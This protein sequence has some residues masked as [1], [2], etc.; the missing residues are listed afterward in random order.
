M[1]RTTQQVLVAFVMMGVGALAFAQDDAPPFLGIQFTPDG[2]SGV[3]VDDVVAGSPADAAGLQVGDVLLS[4][5]DVYIS[6][7]ILAQALSA[8]SVGDTVTLGVVRD[9]ALVEL[10]ATLGERPTEPAEAP[11]VPDATQEA[12]DDDDEAPTTRPVL[13]VTVEEADGGV[14]IAGVG[15]GSPA[16]DAGI[17]AGDVITAIDGESVDDIQALITLLTENYRPGDTVEVT[18]ARDGDEQT[19]EVTLGEAPALPDNDVLIVPLGA[20]SYDEALQAWL[21]EDDALAEFGLQAGDLITEV[22]G[23]VI[24]DRADLFDVLSEGVLEQTI[25]LTVERGDDTLEIEVPLIVVAAMVNTV[26]IPPLEA[27]ELEMVPDGG[28]NMLFSMPLDAIRYDVAEQVWIVETNDLAQ[29]G[30]QM[31]DVITAIDGET[32]ESWAE[33][34]D[35][36]LL[37]SPEDIIRLTVER[38]G[39]IIEVDVPQIMAVGMFNAPGSP[40]LELEMPE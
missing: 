10:A 5:D 21:V 20:V 33:L 22:N 14:S 3:V 12:T 30:L 39:E 6:A 27:P 7:E 4:V 11:V 32:I 34:F 25:T 17:E 18:L 26:A 15:E 1:L 37:T 23:E 24:T 8:Y 35:V 19:V 40:P 29:L 36:T 16:E 28:V 9:G 13:G 31:G 2:V 38:G